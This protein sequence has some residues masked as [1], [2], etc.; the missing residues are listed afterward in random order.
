MCMAANQWHERGPG[1]PVRVKERPYLRVGICAGVPDRQL[2]THACTRAYPPDV[3]ACNH[4]RTQVPESV[5]LRVASI[6]WYQ[7]FIITE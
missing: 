4:T 2:R 3:H 5:L 1:W 7:T 6:A